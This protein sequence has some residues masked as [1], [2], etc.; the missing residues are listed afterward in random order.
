[1]RIKHK[2]TFVKSVIQLIL[3]ITILFTSLYLNRYSVAKIM[4]G[5]SLV[6]SCVGNICNSIKIKR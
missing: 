4:F 6:I 5:I 2:A 1:M 3:G